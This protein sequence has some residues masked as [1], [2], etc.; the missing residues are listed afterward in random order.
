MYQGKNAGRSQNSNAPRFHES[1]VRQ[2]TNVKSANNLNM[3]GDKRMNEAI[4]AYVSENI[5]TMIFIFYLELNT[6]E[7]Y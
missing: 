4:Y 3:V 1:N 7:T 5:Q 2:F 6:L